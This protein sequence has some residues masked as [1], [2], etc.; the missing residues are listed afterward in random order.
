MANTGTQPTMRCSKCGKTFNSETQLQ[1]HGANCQGTPSDNKPKIPSVEEVKEDM[2]I[3]DRF[4][5]TDH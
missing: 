3:E 5:A 1:E 2:E 4:E